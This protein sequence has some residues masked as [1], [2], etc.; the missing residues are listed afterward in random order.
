MSA[1]TEETSVT[2]CPDCGVRE[3]H[4][5]ELGCDMESCPFCGAQ[6]ISCDCLYD[7]LGLVDRE[8][9]DESTSFLP[10]DIYKDGITEEQEA[11]WEDLLAKQGRLPWISYPNVCARCG[12]LSPELFM[13]NDAAWE[14][15]IEPRER[16]HVICRHCFELIRELT[17]KNSGREPVDVVYREVGGCPSLSV[18]IDKARKF[19]T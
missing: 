4:L 9:Y 16:H 13:V 2:E 12:C 6:L 17:D 18:L 3:G 14:H 5:H 19:E 11:V 1:D 8:K 15:Y 7:K 10:P